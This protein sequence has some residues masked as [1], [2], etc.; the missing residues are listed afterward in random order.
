M[1]DVV[2]DLNS[3]AKEVFGDAGVPDL[4]P[5]MTKLQKAIPFSQKE[6]TG[7][8]YVQA[9]RLAYPNGFTHALGDGTAGAFS[10]QDSIGGTQKR[11]ELT[12]SQILL[13]DQMSYE[14][15]HKCAGGEKSF[16][17]GTKYFFEGLQS[18]MRK[19]L[20][21]QLFHGGSSLGICSSSANASAT[22]TVITMTAASWVPGVWVG[23]EGMQ[24][25]VYT[26]ATSDT[27]VSSGADAVFTLVSVDVPN[28]KITISGT[29]G[30][31]STL[32]TSIASGGRAIFYVGAYEK[33]MTGVHGILSNT[34]TLFNIA[35]GTYAQW[36]AAQYAPTSGA[37]TF[38]KV[39]K[40]IAQGVSK[41]LDEDLELY[42][43]PSTWDDLNSDI[44]ALRRTDKSEVAK[45]EIGSEEIVYHSQN[46]KTKLVPSIYCKEGF[47]YGLSVK[48]WKRIGSAD[49]TF[50][51]P[52]FS[53]E[54]FLHLGT[55]AG[56]ESRVYTSQAIICLAP[57]KQI[58]ISNIVNTVF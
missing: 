44:A 48:N 20:E 47:A 17:E 3:L 16:K 55:K 24:F 53:G 2:N 57:A 13:R 19:R 50:N 4:I 21:V 25:N 54:M 46:G 52:G 8:K 15:A 39:K 58:Y 27:L 31:I 18:S 49:V 28:R 40:A 22:S 42:M 12:P 10:L 26:S 14:D 34:G 5:N 29:S 45:V 56:V 36:L 51:T 7:L 11:A 38:A 32:D 6:M 1:A 41:G 9:V 35:G 33:E 43:H 37:L 30:G 23:N